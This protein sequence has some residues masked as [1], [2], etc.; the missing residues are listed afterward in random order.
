M[1]AC[2]ESLSLANCS[3]TQRIVASLVVVVNEDDKDGEFSPKTEI[4]HFW[5]PH[6]TGAAHW[7]YLF[8]VIGSWCAWLACPKRVSPVLSLPRSW[9]LT[10]KMSQHD[11]L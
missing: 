7:A 11:A 10:R 9:K 1:I 3:N 5:H 4:L 8:A 6:A 2:L